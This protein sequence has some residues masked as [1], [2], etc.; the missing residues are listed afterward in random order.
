MKQFYI[1]VLLLLGLHFGFANEK[2]TF[3]PTPSATISGNAT[4]C[5][6]AASPI[7]TFTGSAGTAPY[8]FTYTVSGTPGNQ[9]IQTSSGNSVT[10]TV[11][12]GTVGTITYTLVSVH[13]NVTTAEQSAPGT[14]TVTVSA[15]PTIDFIFNINNSCSGTSVQFTSSVTGTGPYM[16][17]WDFGDGSPLSSSINPTHA[18]L[19]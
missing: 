11:P 15:P 3:P 5:Q 16:Y 6:N 19:H 13:D 18:L 8:H 9:T 14:A 10:L 7:I 4:V 1:A 2:G 17:S 12:T